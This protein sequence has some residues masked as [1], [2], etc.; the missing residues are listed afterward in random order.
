MASLPTPTMDWSNPDRA[1]AL[2]EFQQIAGMWFTI[3][4]IPAADQHTYI[5]MW[6]GKEGL[7][8][9]NTW[10]LTEEDV[11]NPTNI[12]KAFSNQIEP[13]E[14]FRIHRLEFQRYRQGQTEHIDDFMLRCRTKAI[15]CKFN[16]EAIVEERMIE[17]LTAGVR[18][19][20]VQKILLSR[21][22]KLTLEEALKITRTH[23]A[24]AAHMSQLSS[25]DRTPVHALH[26]E[27]TCGNCGTIHEPRQCPC[28]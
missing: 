23:E 21:D 1:Q 27:R 8:M 7:R 22:E 18:H 2:R 5:I 11:K 28:I 10:K 20:E 17:L 25:L 14:N 3:K 9:Y 24:S 12:W 16:N 15:K 4:K 13:Q 19:P 26:T 6:S